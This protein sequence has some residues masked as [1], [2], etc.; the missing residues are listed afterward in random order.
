[1]KYQNWF[2]AALTAAVSAN[3]AVN[4]SPKYDSVGTSKKKKDRHKNEK[5]AAPQPQQGGAN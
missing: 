5:P 2:D 1:M 4:S 3:S